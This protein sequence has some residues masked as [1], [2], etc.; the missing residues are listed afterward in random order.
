MSLF[1]ETHTRNTQILKA[2]RTKLIWQRHS[3]PQG[4]VS[5]SRSAS[6]CLNIAIVFVVL[7]T[8]RTRTRTRY[9]LSLRYTPRIC[10]HI[11]CQWLIAVDSLKHSYDSTQWHGRL[12][13]KSLGGKWAQLNFKF[14]F[15]EEKQI[16]GLTRNPA[17][18]TTVC[19][20]PWWRSVP[21][22]LTHIVQKQ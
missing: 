12:E 4:L 3:D 15:K 18:F 9:I 19:A 10:M 16:Q 20:S 5:Y 2:S 1:T 13:G 6:G 11:F 8:L 7:P 21:G 17:F 22:Y 14:R